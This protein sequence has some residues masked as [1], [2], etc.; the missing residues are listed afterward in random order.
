M[1]SKFAEKIDSPN[2]N[3]TEYL[4]WIRS[5]EKTLFLQLTTSCEV[6]R[7]MKQL[8]NKGSS[9][10]DRINN[11]VLKEISEYICTPLAYLFNESMTTGVFPDM[12]T[13]AEVVPL[14]KGKSRYEVENYR[15]IS[16]LLTISKLLEKLIYSRVYNFLISSNQ[17]YES[18]YGFQRNH[19]CEHAVG[20]FIS[21]VVK[22]CQLGNITVGIF[23]DLS[24]AF[25]TLEHSVIYR[26]LERYGIRENALD[27]F[28]SYLSNRKLQTKCRTAS[29]SIE[30]RS[31]LYKVNYGTP[32]GS[33]LGPLIF[34]IFCN[35]L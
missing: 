19:A 29:S 30:S 21:E 27:W 10:H 15:P 5:N 3:I 32:Q 34:L 28:K 18:Q 11:L 33:C 17:L 2:K 8:P 20:E 31:S 1:G 13:I 24:K 26:K 22:N 9:G 7:L 12:M 16:L 6:L 14:Y 35:D 4:C 23:L 25:D